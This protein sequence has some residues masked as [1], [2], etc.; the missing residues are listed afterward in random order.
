M[1]TACVA[2]LATPDDPVDGQPQ[3]PAG[4]LAG[5][6]FIRLADAVVGRATGA[7]CAV[8]GGV[9]DNGVWFNGTFSNCNPIY[10]DASYVS[11]IT[12]YGSSTV[13]LSPTNASYGQAMTLDSSGYLVVGSSWGASSKFAQLNVSLGQGSATTYRDIDLRGSWSAGEGHAISAT[14]GSSSTDMV[15]QMVFQYDSPGSR[16]KWGRLYHSGNSSVYPMELI[17]QDTATAY[18]QIN[19]GSMRAPIFYDSND[20]SYYVDPNS[21]S[22]LN[23]ILYYGVQ[24]WAGDGAYSRGCPT[25]GYRFN[26]NADTINAFIINN[27][28]D[29]ISYSSSRAPIFYDSNDTGY[30]TD[31]ASTSR[32]NSI[33][34][35]EIQIGRAHV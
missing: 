11:L 28:G 1:A 16:I 31:P 14:Y 23:S 3:P 4:R 27:S 30:Y 26:N 17:S 5:G 34:P 12:T 19:S 18:L 22:V 25:Y 10:V 7:V 6:F 32:L 20:T 8:S 21:T 15:G 35:N 2:S 9:P 29:T 13:T 33:I 24:V